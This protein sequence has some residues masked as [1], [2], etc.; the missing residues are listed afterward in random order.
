MKQYSIDLIV[1]DIM[2]P[3]DD[4][5][6]LC[7]EIRS[8]LD[9]PII[10]LSAADE[11]SDRVVGLEVGADDYLAKPFS[12]REL[13][14]RVKAL[15][16]R[17]SGPM[18]ESR[19]RSRLGRLPCLCFGDWSLDQNKRVLVDSAGVSIPLSAAE[20][21]LLLAFLEHPGRTLSRD[22]L[23]DITRGRQANP[24][25]RTIDVQVARLRKKI[26]EDPKNPMIIVTVRG[27]GYQFSAQVTET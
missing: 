5:I 8:T 18:Q 15:I 26:E 12:P 14:A 6:A 13:L 21:D 25:D 3:G 11:E 7:R 27:G 17:A 10:M 22:Q 24:F 20:Y 4:G 19:Q 23:L 1:L 2:L 16:R 9:T